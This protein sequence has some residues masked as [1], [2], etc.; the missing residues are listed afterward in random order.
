MDREVLTIMPAA[1]HVME[2]CR[3]FCSDRVE[4]TDGDITVR[5]TQNPSHHDGAAPAPSVD[6][7]VGSLNKEGV[8]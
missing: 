2:I 6:G 5:V 3:E 7:I 8:K 4:L 1:R